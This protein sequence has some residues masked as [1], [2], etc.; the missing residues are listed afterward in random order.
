MKIYKAM[1]YLDTPDGSIYQMDVI[2]HDG[3]FVHEH[4]DQFEQQY[5]NDTTYSVP[6]TLRWTWPCKNEQ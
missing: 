3:R 2:Q 5:F 1:V 6:Y 4:P